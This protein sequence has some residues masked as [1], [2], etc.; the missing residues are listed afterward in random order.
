M[1]WYIELITAQPIITAMI[2][3]AVLGT[4]GDA[5]SHWIVKRRIFTPY[6]LKTLILKIIEWSILAVMIKY[7]FIGFHGFIE[8]LINNNY[9]PHFEGID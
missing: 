9:L 1:N 5:V 3:F 6:D 7:A 8:S 4:F 2:Q